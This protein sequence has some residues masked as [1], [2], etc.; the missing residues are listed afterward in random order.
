MN[1]DIYKKGLIVL[2]V[3]IIVLITVVGYKLSEEES[4]NDNEQE[5]I[6]IINT[7]TE[8]NGKNI[9]AGQEITDSSK[10]LE[11]K[12][13]ITVDISGAVKNPGIYTLEDGKRLNDVIE[14][15]GGLTDEAYDDYIALYINKAR[16]LNDEEK[17]YIPKVNDKNSAELTKIASSYINNSSYNTNPSTANSSTSTE[18][19]INIGTKIN[20]NTAS[21]EQLMTLKG[22][23]ETYSQRIIDY[24]NK[25]KFSSIEEIK[26]VKGIGDK[27]FEKIKDCI[28]VE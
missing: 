1:K 5:D 4:K 12:K 11:E 19:I 28:T 21:K 2:S 18:S 14:V 3:I 20:I 15:A 7:K 23:G 25:K 16:I 17:I 10:E 9:E 22:I 24:R 8:N 13:Y 26:N 6:E 27:T